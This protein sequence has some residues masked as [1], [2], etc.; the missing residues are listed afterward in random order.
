[1]E[2]LRVRKADLTLNIFP[3]GTDASTV[4]RANFQKRGRQYLADLIGT[5]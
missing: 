5:H 2:R 3:G 1:M 4:G